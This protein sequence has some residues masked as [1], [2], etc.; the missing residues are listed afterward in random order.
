MIYLDTPLVKDKLLKLIAGQEVKI[1]GSFYT[2][3]DRAHRKLAELITKKKPLP[4]NLKGNI[5]YYCGP[6]FKAGKVASCGPTTASRMDGFVEPF[7]KEGLAAAVGKGTRALYVKDILQKY[8]GVYFVTYAGCAA[9]L[10]QFVK[11]YRCLAFPELGAEAI[12]EFE[13]VDF[14]LIVGIDTRGKDIYARLR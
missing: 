6:N 12:F 10:S 8:K 1:S 4:F 14:P 9:Y 3:R 11:S 2:A 5:I 7:F 13:V